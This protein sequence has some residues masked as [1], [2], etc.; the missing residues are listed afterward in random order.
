MKAIAVLM[1]LLAGLL[2]APEASA[3]PGMP[4]GWHKDSLT[5]YYNH[6]GYT[7]VN[8]N[9][10]FWWGMGATRTICVGP[11]ITN[12]T[13]HAALGGGLITFAYY[14]GSSC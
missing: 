8:I 9:V 10:D 12:L 3:S 4:C 14:N 2:V 7:P 11:G 6:C 13:E 5:D 1:F